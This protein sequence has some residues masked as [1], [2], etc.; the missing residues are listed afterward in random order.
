ME[1]T[2]EFVP[3]V[4]DFPMNDWLVYCR[5]WQATTFSAGRVLILTY[6]RNPG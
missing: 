4:K 5:E 1:I 6:E 3:S 2:L